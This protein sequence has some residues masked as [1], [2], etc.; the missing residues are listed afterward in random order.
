[1]LNESYINFNALQQAAVQETP[2][3]YMIIPNFINPI[4]LDNLVQNFPLIAHRGSIPASAVNCQP[5]FQKFIAELEGETLKQCIA[6]KFALNLQ[7]KPAMLTLRGH[8]TERDGQIH[9]D[10]KDKLIT[11]LLY[12]NPQWDTEN[13]KLRLLNDAA[14]L[15]NYAA[16]I[17]P[18]A[19]S[20]VIFKVT[21]NCWHG[22]K[23]FNGN[24][25]SLQLNYVTGEAAQAKHLNHHR[26]SAW[27]KRLFSRL[28]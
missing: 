9:T 22:H 2:F 15:D 10:S 27:L 26:F 5:A 21:A 24:R 19:G 25:L 6:Q 3:P 1:M 7:Q 12:M 17:S 11:L 28:T 20:C 8:T 13:G 16:E 4:H 14:S 23:P 18:L